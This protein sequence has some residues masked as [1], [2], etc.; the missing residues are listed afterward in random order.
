MLKRRFGFLGMFI[1]LSLGGWAEEIPASQVVKVSHQEG[2]TVRTQ[3][4]EVSEAIVWRK[5]VEKQG[6][7]LIV[8]HNKDPK[9]YFTIS[10]PDKALTVGEGPGIKVILDSKK[11]LLTIQDGA[12]VIE[13]KFKKVIDS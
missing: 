2:Y 4:Y 11:E 13:E 7:L 3:T 10:R 5:G 9:R 1:L 8:Q 6:F 12:K